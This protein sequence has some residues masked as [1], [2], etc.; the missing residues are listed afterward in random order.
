[1]RAPLTPS[2]DQLAPAHRPPGEANKLA[3]IRT[4]EEALERG[5][6]HSFN[7]PFA[8]KWGSEPFVKWA[9]IS[10]ALS[11]LGVQDGAS[12]LDVGCGEGWT[13]LFLAEAGFNPV[14][15]DLAPAR[16]K[17]GIAR[18]ERWGAAAE[19]SVADM[20]TVDLGREFD[21][22]L[23]YDALH[24]T[25][26]QSASVA[27]V[28]SHLRP[29]AWVLFGEPS[30]LHQISPGARRTHRELGWIERGITVRGL[31]RDCAAAGLGNFRRFW[32]PTAPY[33]Q[34]RR[35]LWEGVRLVA[36]NLFVAPH[37]SVWLAAQRLA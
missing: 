22:V 7:K 35:V 33:G 1:M 13:S 6:R 37:A 32:E 4:A 21:F 8:L 9:T 29:A 23:V 10:Y 30:W 14:G 27:R 36:G 3:E 16:V 12:V 17:M 34:R 11:A 20:E 15:I 2:A 18:A 24:H 5:E 31:R 28:A 26:R 25:K 19:F